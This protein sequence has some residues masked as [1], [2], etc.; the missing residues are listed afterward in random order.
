MSLPPQY[1]AFLYAL[2]HQSLFQ[3]Y[4]NRNKALFFPPIHYFLGSLFF[5]VFPRF[6]IISFPSWLSFQNFSQC[7]SEFFHLIYIWKCLC[8]FFNWE[9]FS[10]GLEF[11]IDFFFILSILKI[12]APIFWLALF[13]TRHQLLP[14]SPL[15][16]K[17]QV[18]LGC[19][20]FFLLILSI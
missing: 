8:L 20:Y 3:I 18:L 15:L 2:S 1:F 4:E 7:S 17:S 11:R 13:L 12:F 14:L 5:C 6:Y 9:M 10:L 19:Y 16:C